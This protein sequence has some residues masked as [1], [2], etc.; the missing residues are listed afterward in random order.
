MCLFSRYH[1][2]RVL[3]ERLVDMRNSEG[4]RLVESSLTNSSRAHR[5][6]SSRPNPSAS[7]A[8]MTWSLK[9]QTDVL[10]KYTVYF[11]PYTKQ[12]NIHNNM[13][14]N[15]GYTLGGADVRIDVVCNSDFMVKLNLDTGDGDGQKSS[16]EVW[17]KSRDV[18]FNNPAKQL[19][20]FLR[21]LREVDHMLVQV[22]DSCKYACV[23]VFSFVFLKFRLLSKLNDEN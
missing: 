19:R 22:R 10:L 16:G 8:F 7:R 5:A 12:Q 18:I 23:C 1:L 9:W 11:N 17:N 21:V 14:G 20:H 4:F 13:S 15:S 6:S 3:L 2:P